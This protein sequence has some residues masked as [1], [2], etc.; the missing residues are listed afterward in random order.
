M[1]DTGEIDWLRSIFAALLVGIGFVAGFYS[2]Y[3]H[4]AGET[5]RFYVLIGSFILLSAIALFMEFRST[6]SR[7]EQ[8]FFLL[9]ISIGGLGVAGYQSYEHY[10][11]GSSV[12]DI[13]G[14]FSC[15]TVTESRFG[16][17]PQDSGIALSVYGIF[18]WLGL[19]F[20]LSSQIW[21]WNILNR[22]DFYTLVW[23]FIGFLS[24]IPLLW[25]ELYTLPQEIGTTVICPFCTIQHILIVILFAVSFII[26][27]KPLT[28][29]LEDIF[30]M[31]E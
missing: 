9:L 26:L 5:A 27:H 8:M 18:W 31:E 1:S 7:S 19:M 10:F 13:S 6:V 12:C 24:I 20:L 28:E 3:A 11:I 21:N 14:N 25:I 4:A 17:F 22:E 15:S 16:E 2:I 30:Y 29:H 23:N